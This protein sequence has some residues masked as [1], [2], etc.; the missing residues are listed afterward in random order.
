MFQELTL[1]MS[2]WT[3][4][5][6]DKVLLWQGNLSYVFIETKIGSGSSLLTWISFWALGGFCLGF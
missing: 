1:L 2:F 5:T 4:V 6:P 3:V